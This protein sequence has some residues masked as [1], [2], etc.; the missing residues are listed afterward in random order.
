[1]KV[2]GRRFLR[3][4]VEQF[5]SLPAVAFREGGFRVQQ[6]KVLGSGV[7]G[8][9]F[10]VGCAWAPFRVGGAV[11]EAYGGMQ[12]ESVVDPLRVGNHREVAK[13]RRTAEGR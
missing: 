11:G 12:G 2:E 4:L 10:R 13:P 1:M 9:E 5:N 6:F 3:E 8:S 7:L